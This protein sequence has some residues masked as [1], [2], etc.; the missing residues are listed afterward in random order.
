MRSLVDRQCG[1]GG[2][3]GDRRDIEKAQGPDEENEPTESEDEEPQII[4][5]SCKIV[6]LSQKYSSLPNH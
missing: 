3:T 4:T 5:R 6:R 1:H 2:S